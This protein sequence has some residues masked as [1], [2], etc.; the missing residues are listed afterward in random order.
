MKE[1][2]VTEELFLEYLESYGDI[3]RAA[4]S[5]AIPVS[6]AYAMAD[7]LSDVIIERSKKKLALGSLKA[8]STIVNLMDADGSTEKGELKMKAAQD[9]M[10]RSGVT[11]HSNIDVKVEASNGLFIL[12][13][14]AD[15]PSEDE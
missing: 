1:L 12:P 4:A 13:S 15:V 8:A 9:V 7:R 3:Q 11:K 5:A 6:T 2:S 14:K 10:D